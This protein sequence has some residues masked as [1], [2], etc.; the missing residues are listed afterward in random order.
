MMMLV[1]LHRGL[2]F[3]VLHCIVVEASCSAVAGLPLGLLHTVVS[4]WGMPPVS[5]SMDRSFTTFYRLQYSSASLGGVDV[6]L[7]AGSEE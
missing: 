1:H 4:G 6:A 2:F 7:S 3:S 5:V